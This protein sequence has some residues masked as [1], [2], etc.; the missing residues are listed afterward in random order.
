MPLIQWIEEQDAEGEVKK[1]YEFYF[2][3]RPNRTKV[4]DIIKS[5]ND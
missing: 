3:K 4:A 5:L 1:G 2:Q